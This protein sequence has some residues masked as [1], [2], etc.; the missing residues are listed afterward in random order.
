[1][2]AV[3]LQRVVVRMLHDPDLARACA[4]ADLTP[5]ERGWLE[6]VDP[7][8]WRA[9][10]LRRYRLLHALIEEYPVASALV[11]RAAGVPA[12]DAFF[13]GQRFH[14]TVQRDGRVAEAFGDWLCARADVEPFAAIEAAIERVRRTPSVAHRPDPALQWRAAPWIAWGRGPLD[15]W[16]RL[17]ARLQAHRGGMVAGA[18]DP[19]LRLRVETPIAVDWLVDGSAAPRVEAAP[20]ALIAFLAACSAPQPWAVACAALTAA[21]ADPDEAPALLEGFIEDRLLTPGAD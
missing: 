7:R 18:L 9:D 20:A 10:P 12:F 5:T 2:S 1:M 21:G 16:S 19:K 11:V 13:E 3:A 4:R 6:A 15:A 14:D 17:R 8:R